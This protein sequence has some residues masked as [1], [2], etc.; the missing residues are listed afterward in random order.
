MLTCLALDVINFG[1]GEAVSRASA[2]LDNV[3]HGLQGDEASRRGG[4]VLVLCHGQGP[5]VG[6]GEFN[7]E[8]T[9]LLGRGGT[10]QLAARFY[11]GKGKEE[12]SQYLPRVERWCPVE[13]CPPEGLLAR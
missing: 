7:L 6:I 11:R 12:I 9:I 2:E 3:R 5:A 1:Y 4:R 13:C 8:D 10:R